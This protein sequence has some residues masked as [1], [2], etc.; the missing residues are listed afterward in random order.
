MLSFIKE[1]YHRLIEESSTEHRRSLYDS[2][3]IQNRLT[4]LI[5]PRGV[6]KT[7][8]MLQYI[9]ENLFEEGK[10]FYFSADFVYFNQV[11]LVEFV[12]NLHRQEGIDIF[13]IDEIHKY[14]NW[15][16][17]LKNLYDAYPNLTFVFSGSSMMDLIEGSYDLSRRAKLYSLE[18]MSFREY[19]NFV[20]KKSYDPFTFQQLITDYR[21]IGKKLA[22]IPQV[23]THFQHYLQQGYYPFVFEDQ[24]SFYEKLLRVVEKTIFEDIANFYNLKTPNLIYFKKI[25]GYLASIPPGEISTNNIARSLKVDN[26][27]VDHYLMILERVGFIRFI[28][29][30]EGGHQLLR[31]P[32]KIFLHNTNLLHALNR[33]IG[34]ELFRGTEREVFFTQALNDAGI[35][36]FY[37]SQGDFVAENTLFEVGGKNKTKRQIKNAKEQAFLVKEGILLSQEKEIPLFYFGFLKNH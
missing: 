37:S 35:D 24:H 16:Q 5:G 2:F 25:L 6:G 15:N 13:F 31:K 29:H 8:L 17:E 23:L 7:T 19:L 11:S 14:H 33:T 28:Y 32:Q 20:T 34:K 4:G 26:K 30:N 1:T 9:K 18:G 10:T 27:T 3:S 22:E 36:T 21:A 12:S